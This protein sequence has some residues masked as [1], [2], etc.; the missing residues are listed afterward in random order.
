MA[1]NS[2]WIICLAPAG[3]ASLAP[4][5]L[6]RSIEVAEKSPF[7]WL[8]GN[9]CDEQLQPLLRAL[10]AVVRYELFPNNR[11]RRLEHRIPSETLPA[12]QW[13][14]LST[15]LRVEMPPAF[16]LP[17]HATVVPL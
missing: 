14:P 4:L 6:S 9:N 3:A 15:W 12:L 17:E 2:S 13:Q 10:P 1:V 5:R 16:R 11:L 8:R 7:I